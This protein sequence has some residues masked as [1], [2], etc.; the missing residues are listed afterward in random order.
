[1]TALTPARRVRLAGLIVLV[2]GGLAAALV[3][4]TARTAAAPD[5]PGLARSE[6]RELERLGGRATARTVAFDDWLASL[7]HGERLG[8]TLAALSLV[9]GGACLHVAGL[10]AEAV[11]P[12]PGDGPGDRA[13]GPETRP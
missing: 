12:G 1:M 10:M 4:A 13:E 9:V 7:W 8:W 5:A 6:T 11:D 3:V 2:V